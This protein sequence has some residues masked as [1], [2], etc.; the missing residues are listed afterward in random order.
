MHGF[1]GAIVAISHTMAAGASSA[2]RGAL[3]EDR[4][5]RVE[6]QAHLAG[7]DPGGTFPQIYKEV[8]KRKASKISFP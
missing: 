5:R 4:L 3:L 8:A 2:L 7:E 6:K 1:Y